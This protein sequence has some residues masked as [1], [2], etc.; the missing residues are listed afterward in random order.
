MAPTTSVS[1]LIKRLQETVEFLKTQTS[2]KPQVGV[3]LG[4]GLGAFAREIAVEKTIPFHDIPH[5]GKASVEGH[6]GNLIFGKM[7]DK[8]IVALQGRLHYYEGHSLDTVVFPLRVMALMG[9]QIMVLTNSA[10]GLGDGMKAGDFMIIEDHINLTGANPLMGP[11]MK[12]LGPRFPDMSEAYDRKLIALLEEIF[13]Q[14]NVSFHRG[15][16][17][18]VTGPTYE[19]PAEVRY[20]KQI[21]CSAV[22]MSTVPESIAANHMGLR[23]A[24]LSCITNLA[25]GLSKHKLT[26]E[27]VT[28]TA[29]RVEKDFASILKAFV[30]KL[31]I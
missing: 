10:G 9:V 20:L 14:Q 15:V 18:G 11:N 24:A 12:E 4:S 27:E 29:K 3:I 25:A 6:S 30:Q 13:K 7:G 22:G 26:H 8:S 1:D 17:A 5:F 28:E 23:V 19:T 31:A 16:Y 2:I 21:G